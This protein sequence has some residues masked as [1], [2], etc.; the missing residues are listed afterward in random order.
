MCQLVVFFRGRNTSSIM[1]DAHNAGILDPGDRVVVVAR[2]GDEL[3]EPGDVFPG[4]DGGYGVPLTGYAKIIVVANGGTTAQQAPLLFRLGQLE[5]F[6]A[7]EA[8][9][10]WELDREPAPSIRV[11]VIDLQ[12]GASPVILAE[13]S[14]DSRYSL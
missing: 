7:S 13:G 9:R 2:K 12:R 6:A 8:R 10:D 11:E 4:W 3:A 1:N 5:G 14:L